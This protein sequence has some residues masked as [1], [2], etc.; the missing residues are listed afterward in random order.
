MENLKDEKFII[1]QS[2]SFSV[3]CN[4]VLNNPWNIKRHESVYY[5]KIFN[6]WEERIFP[7]SQYKRYRIKETF[8]T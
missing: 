2:Y 1:Q 5:T 7:F 6:N 4:F 8:L 3:S